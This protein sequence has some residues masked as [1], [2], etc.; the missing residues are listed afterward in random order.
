MRRRLLKWLV[1]PLCQ[2]QLGL[3]V[4]ESER[5]PLE[6]ADRVALE[7]IAPFD[8]MEEVEE[9]VNAGAL[10]CEGCGLYY[11]VYNGVP[12]MLTYPTSVAQV[13]AERY[14]KWVH[15]H[16][17]GYK[18]PEAAPTPGE[19]SVLRNFSREWTGYKWTGA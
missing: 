19:E 11:P 13:H 16:L 3:M 8:H 6:M 10:T 5:R 17:A 4:A 2:H 1:C 12:R 7:K 9:E 14:S 18:L 15:E